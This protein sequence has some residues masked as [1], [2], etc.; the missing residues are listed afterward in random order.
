MGRMQYA[1]LVMPATRVDVAVSL[2]SAE[3]NLATTRGSTNLQGSG[4][5]AGPG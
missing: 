4:Y 1:R 2:S 5:S 3:R